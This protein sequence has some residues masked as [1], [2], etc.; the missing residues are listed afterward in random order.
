MGMFCTCEFMFI[1]GLLRARCC[2]VIVNI[3]LKADGHATK[4]QGFNN[5]TLNFTS[6]NLILFKAD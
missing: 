2:Y 3:S 1:F 4:Q 5:N 6:P